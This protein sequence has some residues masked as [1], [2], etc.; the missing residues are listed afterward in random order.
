MISI[1][2][3]C[4]AKVEPDEYL[5]HL[6]LLARQGWQLIAF[7][8]RLTGGPRSRAVVGVATTGEEDEEE[9]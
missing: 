6:S 8:A 3:C 9:A 7:L 5:S 1:K 4:M 2:L